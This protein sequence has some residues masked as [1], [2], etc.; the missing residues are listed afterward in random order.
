MTEEEHGFV[1][2]YRPRNLV[3]AEMFRLALEE[4]GIRSLVIGEYL[5]GVVGELPMGWNTSP[6]L[7]VE[8]D[9]AEDAAAVL[10]PLQ[11]LQD[12]KRGQEPASPEESQCLSCG[13]AM[14]EADVCPACGW[15]YA[16]TAEV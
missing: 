3:Q 1:E 6:R 10:M 4:A 9:R 12:D 16:A 2:L 8:P 13:A 14:G 7:L 15:T 5:Q 11:K